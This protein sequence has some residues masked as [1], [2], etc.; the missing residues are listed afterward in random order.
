MITPVAGYV[1]L[2]TL[3]VILGVGAIAKLRAISVFE[4]AVAG[5]R[6]LPESTTGPFAL[7]FAVV[8]LASAVLLLVPG[9]RIWGV[10]CALVI[11]GL[12][13]LGILVNLVRGRVDIDCGC[14]GLSRSDGSGLSWWFV[15][16]NGGLLVLVVL[17]GQ[18][19]AAQLSIRLG[20]VDLVTCIAATLTLLGLYAA[21]TQLVETHVRMR[22]EA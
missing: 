5:Y 2:C 14:G 13:T 9:L 20:W 1:A 22:R 8:E 16:R 19:V 3:A 6:L 11:I 12:A 17:A 18:L 4:M 10:V 15:A 7:S 21:V